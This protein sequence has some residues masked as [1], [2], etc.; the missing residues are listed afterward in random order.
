MQRL[1]NKF[2]LW[3]TCSAINT[4]FQPSVP[5]GGIIAEMGHISSLYAPMAASIFLA[6]WTMAKCV[7]HKSVRLQLI[8]GKKYPTISHS[9]IWMNLW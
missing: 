2:A 6:R 4:E 5:N 1:R 7:Y 8:C 3:P 9:F